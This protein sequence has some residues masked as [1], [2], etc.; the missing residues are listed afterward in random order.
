MVKKFEMENPVEDYF[1]QE[2][3]INKNLSVKTLSNRLNLR[4]K[5]VYFYIF[6]SNNLERVKPIEVG[7][8]G[9]KSR[10]FKYT[11]N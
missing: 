1:K 9:S 6:N 5:D 3:N 7:F 10:V 11:D 2:S 8:L 4:K